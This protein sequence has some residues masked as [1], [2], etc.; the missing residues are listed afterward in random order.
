[1]VTPFWVTGVAANVNVDTSR[2]L[3]ARRV[4]KVFFMI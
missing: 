3:P 1:V 2:R 4:F